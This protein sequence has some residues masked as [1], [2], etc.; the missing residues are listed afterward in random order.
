MASNR[1]GNAVRALHEQG[2]S[3]AD[4]GRRFGV[5]SSYFSQIARGA[6]KGNRYADAIEEW[7]N[8]GRPRTLPPRTKYTEPGRIRRVKGG[9]RVARVTPGPGDSFL[10][11]AE[12]GTDVERILRR[13]GDRRVTIRVYAGR[14]VKYKPRVTEQP[15]SVFLFETGGWAASKVLN[16]L[17]SYG[18]PYMGGALLELAANYGN[19]IEQIVGFLEVD[20][21]V[22]PG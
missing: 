12:K 3:Y 19:H 22:L 21:T 15:G 10:A 8:E 11:E 20:I 16:E 1:A 17:R 4:M 6:P 13:A 2:I 14:V 9:E 18:E 7:A 5:D